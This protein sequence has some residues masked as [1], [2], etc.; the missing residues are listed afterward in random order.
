MAAGG[1]V[2]QGVDLGMWAAKTFVVARA[3]HPGGTAT[4][5]QQHAAHKRVGF[6]PPAAAGGKLQGTL[7][8]LRFVHETFSRV[9]GENPSYY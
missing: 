1:R 6:G 8:G 5:G 2:G 4:A 3:D 9:K 7:H